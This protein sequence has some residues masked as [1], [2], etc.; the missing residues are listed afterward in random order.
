M[1]GAEWTF[2]AVTTDTWD[3]MAALFAGKGGPKGCWCMMWRMDALGQVA[4]SAAADRRHALQGLVQDGKAVGL[5]GYDADVPVAWCS[6]APRPLFAT[7]MAPGSAEPGLWS[8]TCFFIRADHRKQAG[9]AALLTAAEHH[10]ATG[11]ARVIE[12][13]PVDPDSPSYRFSGFL[14]SFEKAGYRAVGR[15]GLR[16]HVVRKRLP[17]T[18]V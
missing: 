9:F 3:D 6:I 7:G 10:A 13:Y 8:L 14:P 11:G 16:R 5:L 1:G 2:R 18:D 4:P 12:A 15:I 17:G